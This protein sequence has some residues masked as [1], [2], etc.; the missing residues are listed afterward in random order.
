M[1]WPPGGAPPHSRFPFGALS[2][3][4]SPQ[5]GGE[6]IPAARPVV[7]KL[8]QLGMYLSDRVIDEALQLVGE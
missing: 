8:R 5:S 4:S 7:A 3:L 1:T 2:D 6:I